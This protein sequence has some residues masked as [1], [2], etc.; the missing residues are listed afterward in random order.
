MN[1]GK[2]KGRRFEPGLASTTTTDRT[3]FLEPHHAAVIVAK[4]P[5]TTTTKN[6]NSKQKPMPEG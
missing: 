2:A 5:G 6:S 1:A 3:G 4:E